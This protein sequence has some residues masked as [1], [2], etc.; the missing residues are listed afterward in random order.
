MGVLESRIRSAPSGPSPQ[1][2]SPVA[3]R[4]TL[5][6]RTQETSACPVAASSAT[7]RASRSV[8][9][10]IRGSPGRTSSPRRRMLAPAPSP[11]GGWT[12]PARWT[13]RSCG[14]TRSAPAGTGAP[15][16]TRR[17]SPGPRRPARS[18]ALTR[19]ATASPASRTA[20]PM[21]NPSTAEWSKGGKGSAE[22][23][24]RASVQPA[25]SATGRCS[26][27]A[28]GSTARRTSNGTSS[29]GIG[30]LARSGFT[31]ASPRTATGTMERSAG[32]RADVTRAR[33]ASARGPPRGRP[34]RP[35]RRPPRPPPPPHR[36]GPRPRRASPRPRAPP[37]GRRPA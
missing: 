14:A 31:P 9:A 6:R 24:G 27:P 26:I 19:P 3:S 20:A 4:A 5:R 16:I 33:W 12:R 21:A 11:A 18:P 37:R 1:S 10:G 36:A 8:P 17:A 13:H 34:D 7:W 28:T 22:V 35:A 30:P 2:S 29:T 25:A 32:P 23:R 15:V